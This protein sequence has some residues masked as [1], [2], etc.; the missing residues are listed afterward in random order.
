QAETKVR[1]YQIRLSVSGTAD[2]AVVS[3]ISDPPLTD[4]NILAMLALGKTG[5]ELKGKE[6]GVGV[7]EATSFATGKFQ[8]IL[9]SRAR[10][11]TG[12]DRFQVDP[13]ISKSDTAVPR[14]TVGKEIIQDKL[15]MTY[16]SN[17]GAT[18]PE[19]IFRIEYL[20]NKNMSLVGER[21]ELGN[22]GADIKFRFEFK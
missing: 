4:S 19:Q 10:S 20:L 1:E 14:V 18:T 16:S 6:A 8:D 13:Y 9:E 11:L 21:N 15:M 12:L 2:R 7:G 3:F 5:A 22:V 17:V